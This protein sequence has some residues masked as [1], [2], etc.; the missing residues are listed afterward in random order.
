MSLYITYFYRKYFA[1]KIKLNELNKQ[2]IN[3]YNNLPI[4]NKPL[5]KSISTQTSFED[6]SIIINNE[7]DN[8]NDGEIP[9]Q[10]FINA[11]VHLNNLSQ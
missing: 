8:V 1:Y 4:I 5:Q 10:S 7:D 3:K 11:G 6:L 9:S 2:F